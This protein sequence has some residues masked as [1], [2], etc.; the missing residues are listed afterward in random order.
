MRRQRSCLLPFVLFCVSVCGSTSSEN[1]SIS[2]SNATDAIC[3]VVYGVDRPEPLPLGGVV[4]LLDGG[5]RRTLSRA[6]DGHFCFSGV[7]PGVHLVE[8]AADARRLPALVWPV[9]KVQLGGKGEA[10]RAVEYAHPGAHRMH[11]SLPLALRPV[12]AVPLY[13]ERPAGS[14]LAFLANPQVLLML[15]VGVMSLCLPALQ[16][17]MDPEALKEMQEQQA[18][19]ADPAQMLKGLFGG[20]APAPAPAPA[21]RPVADAP[22]RSAKDK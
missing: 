17:N 15:V 19:M 14:P 21:P 3:G 8:A 11:A 22:R 5:A 1:S 13:E 7:A 10:S 4:L 20:G 16:R 12:A 2:A 9:F 6:S 18:A